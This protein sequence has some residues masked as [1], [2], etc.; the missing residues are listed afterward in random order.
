MSRSD[1]LRR[2]IDDFFS[3]PI[4]RDTLIDIL[5]RKDSGISLRQ[6]EWFITSYSRKNQTSY[7]SS[8][9]KIFVVHSSYKSS[10][11]GYS[12]KLFDPFCRTAKIDFTIPGT[13]RTV[14]TT[15]AQLNFLKWC[16]QKGVIDYM[17]QHKDSLKRTAA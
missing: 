1:I 4:N 17:R 3:E 10:L 13:D 15:L 12:K 6:I 11:D 7:V 14:K 8:D 9:N 2:S 16:Q 5:E